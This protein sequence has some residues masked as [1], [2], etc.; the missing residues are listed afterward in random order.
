MS[1][2]SSEKRLSSSDGTYRPDVAAPPEG[3]ASALAGSDVLL[4]GVDTVVVTTSAPRCCVCLLVQNRS[5]G[6]EA[7]DRGI[8]TGGPW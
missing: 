6:W 1:P 8:A 2:E 5:Q 4:E 3:G 7:G